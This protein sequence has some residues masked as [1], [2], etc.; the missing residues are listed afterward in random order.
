MDYVKQEPNP[1]YLGYLWSVQEDFPS[2]RE[3]LTKKGL[4]RNSNAGGSWTGLSKGPEVVL[5]CPP[6]G[7]GTSFIN[8]RPQRS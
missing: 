2:R 4:I 1:E 8:Q 3:A 6:H 5:I 7:K